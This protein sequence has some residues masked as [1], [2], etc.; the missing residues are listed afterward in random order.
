[1]MAYFG[2]I[3]TLINVPRGGWTLLGLIKGGG[4]LKG[5]L[6]WRNWVKFD[7]DGSNPADE[8][9]FL[10]KAGHEQ[11]KLTVAGHGDE[12]YDG[13]E[14][15]YIIGGGAGGHELFIENATLTLGGHDQSSEK[16]HKYPCAA[17]WHQ[18]NDTTRFLRSFQPIIMATPSKIGITWDKWWYNISQPTQSEGTKYGCEVW[19]GGGIGKPCIGWRRGDWLDPCVANM[20]SVTFFEKK[21][22]G[23]NIRSVVD[24]IESIQTKAELMKAMEEATKPMFEFFNPK[25][26]NINPYIVLSTRFE[27]DDC[28]LAALL[29]SYAATNMRTDKNYKCYHPNQDNSRFIKGAKK[30]ELTRD[31]NVL[32][33]RWLKVWFMVA[34]YCHKT[35]DIGSYCIQIILDE[36]KTPMQ[37]D[38]VRIAQLLDVPVLEFHMRTGMTQETT[39]KEIDE[40][41]YRHK[42]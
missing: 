28:W 38:E 19:S 13:I 14:L 20:E 30:D 6:L 41:I 34:F 36:D 18:H 11:I 24:K 23:S 10:A 17:N 1:M 21:T 32:N 39:Q 15:G 8:W 22:D 12:G 27:R 29:M 31:E 25:G 7:S 3:R 33:D 2:G 16:A 35:K 9:K 42:P 37:K 5:T 26:G 40:F 4:N